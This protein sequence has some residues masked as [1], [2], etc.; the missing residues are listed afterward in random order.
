MNKIVAIHQPN[1]FPWL[2]YFDKIVRSRI[3]I[4]LDDVQFEKK[5]GTWTNR[6][7]IAI[8]KS[9][10]WLTA[11]IDR[12]YHGTRA[13]NE[14]QFA[15]KAKWRRKLVETIRLNYKKASAFKE[16]FPV[17]EE[18]LSNKTNSIAKYNELSI[19]TLMRHLEL[20][21]TELRL[22]SSLPVGTTGTERLIELVKAVDG[23]A[24]LCGG[25]AAGYQQDQLFDDNRIKLVYQNFEHPVY[26]QFHSDSFIPGL[27]IIDALMNHGFSGVR[28]L[29]VRAANCE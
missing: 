14:M 8:N 1:F 27:S 20:Q 25:G 22:S 11:P 23:D 18:L 17:I 28:E 9:A 15:S 4:L 12:A 6:V 16:C 19:R 24:Y 13:I 26:S 3:F 10:K 29:I 5:G 21:Q 2:G 7:K